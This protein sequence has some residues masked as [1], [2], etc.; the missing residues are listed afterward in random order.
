M[1]GPSGDP[2]YEMSR[3]LELAMKAKNLG[4]CRSA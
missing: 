3:F 2:F 4:S 1:A